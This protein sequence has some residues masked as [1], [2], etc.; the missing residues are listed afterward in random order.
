MA[1]DYGL[2]VELIQDDK[3]NF[4]YY[5]KDKLMNGAFLFKNYVEELYKLKSES[6]MAKLLLNILW[7]ALCENSTKEFYNNCQNELDLIDCDITDLHF[8]GTKFRVEIV[9]FGDNYYKT[10]YA[11][12]KPFVLSYGRNHCYK[13]FKEYDKDI[14][15]VH[16]DGIYCQRSPEKFSLKIGGVK[17]D[18]MKN[19]NL[20]GLNKGLGNK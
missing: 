6:K 9:N 3:P 13:T 15:R 17:I 4:L 11:R 5:S 12:I 7:G 1:L 16:T 8:T 14:I 20:T 19:V 18:R 10:N 2:S